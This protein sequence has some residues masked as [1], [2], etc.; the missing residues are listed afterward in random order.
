MIGSYA[1]TFGFPSNPTFGVGEVNNDKKA[2]VG[3]GVATFNTALNALL[4]VAEFML[5]RNAF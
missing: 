5:G 4:L 3:I 2:L 1:N